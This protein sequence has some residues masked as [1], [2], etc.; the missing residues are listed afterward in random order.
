M[1]KNKCDCDLLDCFGFFGV[2][3]S[4]TIP[5]SRPKHLPPQKITEGSGEI[6]FRSTKSERKSKL[7]RIFDIIFE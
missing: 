6:N 3:P 7:K 5:P 4:K 2:R 1:C